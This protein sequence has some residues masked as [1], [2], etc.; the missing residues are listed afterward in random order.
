[1]VVPAQRRPA[2]IS[3]ASSS[4]EVRFIKVLANGTERFQ[5]RDD[6]V[7]DEGWMKQPERRGGCHHHGEQ[8]APPHPTP[9]CEMRVLNQHSCS[10][11]KK[12]CRGQPVTS[13]S[14]HGNDQVMD[15]ARREKYNH[16]GRL[17]SDLP[18][19]RTEQVLM[20]QIMKTRVPTASPKFAE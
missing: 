14:R 9:P 3:P 18:A 6:H 11:Q 12:V 7:Q 15:Q 19:N 8:P 2:C 5:K 13:A 10:L 4:S 17:R 1:M 16:R 20:A